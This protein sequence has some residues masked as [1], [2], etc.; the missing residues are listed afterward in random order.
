MRCTFSSKPAGSGFSLKKLFHIVSSTI[1]RMMFYRWHNQIR[2]RCWH[3]Q[4]TPDNTYWSWYWWPPR[5]KSINE[6]GAGRLKARNWR[7]AWDASKW[8]TLTTPHYFSSGLT[9]R[10]ES[11]LISEFFNGIGTF[12]PHILV[13]VEG[14]HYILHKFA[15]SHRVF[16]FAWNC[17]IS[18][19]QFSHRY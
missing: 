12:S 14:A 13:S 5:R 1:V 3:K 16:S 9:R 17:N 18:R 4:V 8:L 15:E 7:G 11:V 6:T 2:T 19:I 10:I